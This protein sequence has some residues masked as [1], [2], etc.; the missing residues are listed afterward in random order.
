[1]REQGTKTTPVLIDKPLGGYFQ[2]W[3]PYYQVAQR[4]QK[5]PISVSPR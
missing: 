3:S 2:V 1:M 4:N 5:T